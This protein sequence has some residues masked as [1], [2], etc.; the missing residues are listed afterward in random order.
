MS[1]FAG[2]IT[3]A[4]IFLMM[5]VDDILEDVGAVS[6]S[7]HLRPP[8]GMPLHDI[9]F[10]GIKDAGF[11]EDMFRYADF[12]AVMQPAAVPDLGNDRRRYIE[13]MSDLESKMRHPIAMT[14][15]IRI[16][17]L[18]GLGQGKQ[19]AFIRALQRMY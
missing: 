5:I 10:L 7:G 2:R 3:R 18:N 16:L 17:K 19:V 1:L 13:R 6:H 14:A 9:H 12:A 15:G 8:L 11:V 4:V